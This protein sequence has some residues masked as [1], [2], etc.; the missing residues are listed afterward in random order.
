MA[1]LSNW[2]PLDLDIYQTSRAVQFIMLL[3]VTLL[4]ALLS[5]IN[6]SSAWAVDEPSIEHRVLVPRYPINRRATEADYVRYSIAASNEMMT[7]YNAATG[8]FD[9][10]WWNSANVVTTLAN[11]YEQFPNEIRHI[12]DQV[13]PTTLQQAPT[14][15]GFTGFLNGF[16]DDELWW[17]LA[18]IK[19]FDVTGEKKYLD[20]AAEI[21]EDS[22]SSFGTSSCGALWYVFFFPHSHMT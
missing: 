4:V 1:P 22:K 2:N 10:A 16:Y 8:L 15:F 13:F 9:G 11:L 5:Q 14:A 3:P 7:W 12:T 21:F 20:K 18:W 6:L 17:T 19:V